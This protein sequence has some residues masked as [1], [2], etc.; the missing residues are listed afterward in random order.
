[1]IQVLVAIN[2]YNI[3]ELSAVRTSHKKTEPVEQEICI[4]EL[5]Y[6]GI[7]VDEMYFPYGNGIDMA[8]AMLDN[9]AENHTLYQF[10]YAEHMLKETNEKTSTK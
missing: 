3:A 10:I 7:A 4:Y 8:K 1:M 2:N 6:K 9:Y 5:R